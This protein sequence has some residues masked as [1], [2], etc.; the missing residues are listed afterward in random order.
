MREYTQIVIEEA[1]RLKTL[2]NRVLGPN[3]LP[4]YTEVNIHQV[5][6]RVYNLVKAEAG[7][8]VELVRDYDPSIPEVHADSD[9]LIQAL[10]NI[11]QNAVRAVGEEGRIVLRTRIQRNF[12][13][14]SKCHRLVAQI[15]IQDNGPGIPSEILEKIFY[16][17]VSASEGGLGLGLS[18]AQTLINQHRG[19]IECRTMPGETVF[20]VLLPVE[21]QHA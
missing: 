2:V 13:I 1:D 5:L 21:T 3:K 10:L 8:K 20:T 12:T 16:P 14:G 4:H 15:D 17:M 9:Q 19:L 7:Q 11:L 6:D 18:I